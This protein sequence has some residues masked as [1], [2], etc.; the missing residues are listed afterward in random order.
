M[1]RLWL[2]LA[3]CLLSL[4]APAE[5]LRARIDTAA[6]AVEPKVIA[7]RRD[8]HEHP[9]LSNREFRTAK[10]VGD[11]LEAL[12]F[13]VRREVAHTGV[14]GVLRG[15]RPGPVVALRADMDALPVTEATD[16]PF[17]SKVRTTYLGRDVGVMHACGH[18][19]HT[20][21]LM[22]VAD[23][24]WI[25]PPGLRSCGKRAASRL[26][27]FIAHRPRGVARFG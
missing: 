13:E 26:S 9:E 24:F 5:D 16:L 12:G 4:P 27:R 8:L 17:A 1:T 18:D 22:G 20:S 10:L 19:G 21:V 23:S 15:G 11:H 25:E 6:K 3:L 2:P 14:V 7:W